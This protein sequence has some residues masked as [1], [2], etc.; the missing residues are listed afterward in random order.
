MFKKGDL[1][2]FNT[3]GVELF[4]YVSGSVAVVFSD[5]KVMYESIS[6]CGNNKLQM[7]TYD[8]LVCGELFK[9]VPEEFLRRI[10]YSEKDIE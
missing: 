5:K 3:S 8:I 10:A 7:Y 9:D 1:L 2:K 6:I 4:R